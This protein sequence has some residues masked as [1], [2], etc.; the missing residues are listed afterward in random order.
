MVATYENEMA[1]NIGR[2][3]D[4]VFICR[5]EVPNISCLQDEQDDPVNA[6]DQ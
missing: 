6:G 4:E 1:S 2:T 5:V 3:L